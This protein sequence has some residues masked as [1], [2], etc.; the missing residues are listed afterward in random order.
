MV[1]GSKTCKPRYNI[2]TFRTLSNHNITY[3]QDIGYVTVIVVVV[4]VVVIIIIGGGV[5]GG[6][7]GLV[8]V[9]T[10]DCT[11]Q[12]LEHRNLDIT[13]VRSPDLVSLDFKG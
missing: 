5:V 8:D 1:A 11:L 7:L 9:T 2:D 4:V 6:V 10:T 13:L 12:I 3:Q